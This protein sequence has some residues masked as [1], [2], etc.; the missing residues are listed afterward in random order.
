[1]TALPTPKFTIGQIVWLA[2]AEYEQHNIPC[3]DCLGRRSWSVTTPAGESFES[4]CPTCERGFGGSTGCIAEYHW[5]PSVRALTIGSVRIDTSD[6]VPIRYMAHETGVGS[7]T[8]WG[9]GQLHADYG[10]AVTAADACAVERKQY[11]DE[12]ERKRR[13]QAMKKGVRKPRKVA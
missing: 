12:E 10:A 3:P 5:S 1:M 2:S 8:L 4:P 9:E 7:G 11:A 6:D 13:E